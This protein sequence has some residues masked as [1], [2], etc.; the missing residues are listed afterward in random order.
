M[1]EH[2]S[3]DEIRALP[4][5]GHDYQKLYAAYKAASETVGAPTVILAKTV[6]GWTL[7]EGFEGRNA[8]H[9]IKKMTKQQLLELRAR[10]YLEDE[11]P[12]SSLD[13]DL[14]PYYRP[15]VGSDIHTY[16]MDRRRA[17]DGP[18]PKRVV[19]TRRR[20]ELPDPKIFAE[21]DEGSGGPEVSTTMV[22]TAVLRNLEIYAS[23]GQLYEP[24]DHDLLLSYA[25]DTDGQIL[26][27]GITEAGSMASW[28]AAATSYANLGVPMVPFFTFYS[29]F[30]FQRVGDL[31][32]SAADS[33]ARGFLMAA[34]AGRTTLMGEGLQHQDGH[35]LVLAS[36]VPAC[37]AYDPAFA[38][39]VGAIV[40]AGMNR[41]YGGGPPEVTDVFY[42]ITLYNENYEMPPLPDTPGLAEA[43]VEGLYKWA[44]APDGPSIPAT[45]LFSGTAYP[46]ARE[47]VAELAEH[48]DVAA[49]LWSATSYKSLREEGLAAERW[50]RLHPSQDPRTPRVAEI[51]ADSQGPI[52]AVS[53]FMKI[54][55]EQV[56]RFVSDRTFVPLGTDGMGRSDTREALRRHFEVDTGHV[57]LAV[58]DGLLADGKVDESVVADAISRYDIDPDAVDPYLI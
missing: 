6:K 37:Q 4:R 40:Q 19:R 43:I 56:Q 44:D 15:P 49:E 38:Y 52:I 33:R 27:E 1:V 22:F 25:E 41:M 51:L 18:L 28:I 42:Y 24:V 23:K 9:Q 45:I 32:W 13:D 11:I 7:G 57:V 26:E 48:Y 16:M 30:G 20:L 54:V 50:N 10:L 3:D 5:G 17:L 47:A 14:P 55:P 46:A 12:E 21:Y 35:S 34:T 8:T 31:I 39:E 2:L 29:M 58:L 53:D 36:T